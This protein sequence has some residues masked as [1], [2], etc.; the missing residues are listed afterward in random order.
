MKISVKRLKQI[1]KEELETIAEYDRDHEGIKCNVA[2]PGM[3]HEKW[4]KGERSLMSEEEYS[5]TEEELEE[6]EVQKLEE[7]VEKLKEERIK[8]QIRGWKV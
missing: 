6:I 5:T 1:I 2:H 3:E 7:K 8:K 4:A